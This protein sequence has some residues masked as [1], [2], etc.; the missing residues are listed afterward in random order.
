MSRFLLIFLKKISNGKQHLQILILFAFWMNDAFLINFILIYSVNTSPPPTNQEI[1]LKNPCTKKKF[2][3][4]S[5]IGQGICKYNET[6]KS[7]FPSQ[8]FGL[9][10]KFEFLFGSNSTFLISLNL[11]FLG[12]SQNSLICPPPRYTYL[13][14]FLAAMRVHIPSFIKTDPLSKLSVRRM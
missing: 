5:S 11:K 9:P 1:C 13:T 12:A 6:F 10:T 8:N 3:M 7:N 2:N 4:S 14:K